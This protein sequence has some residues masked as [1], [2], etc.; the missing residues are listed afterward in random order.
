MNFRMKRATKY[1]LPVMMALILLPIGS[2]LAANAPY[3]TRTLYVGGGVSKTKDTY[4]PVMT[5]EKFGEKDLKT[6]G[7]IA[8]SPDGYLYIADTGNGR[9][10]K[11]TMDGTLVAEIGK[12]QLKFPKGVFVSYDN[13][14]YVADSRG[15]AVFLFDATG[16][17]IRQ[18]TKPD[19]VLYGRDVDFTP[20]KVVADRAGNVYVI[21]EGNSGGVIQLSREGDFFGYVGA[22]KT[23]LSLDEIIRRLLFTSEQQAQLK[24]NVPVSPIN[25]AIDSRGLIYTVTQG[26]ADDALKKFNMAGVNMFKR[27]SV[28]ALVADVCLSAIGNIYT[29]SSDGYI[30]E[31][32][33]DGEFLYLF[34]G[35]D[36]GYN[37][38]G[39]FIAAAGIAVDDA[40]TLYVLDSE[41]KSATVFKPT[42]YASTVH[43]ALE[44][45]QKGQYIESQTPWESALSQDAM[46]SLAYRGIGEAY[47]KQ[48]QYEKAMYAFREGYAYTGYSE[49]FWET[50]NAWLMQNL[51]YVFL[52]LTGLYIA[53]K[54]IGITNRRYGWLAPAGR[55]VHRLSDVPILKKVAYMTQVPRN[56]A[57]AFYGIRHENKVSVASSTIVY[58]LFF[59]AYLMGKYWTAF[60]FKTVPDGFFEIGQDFLTVFGV[61]ALSIITCNLICSIQDGEARLKDV[62]CS[63]A[64]C[65]MPYIFIKPLLTLVS[66]GLTNNEAFIMQIGD[67]FIAASIAVLILVMVK[68]IQ[69]YTFKKTLWC[70]LLTFFTM[71]LIFVT[72]VIAMILVNQVVDFVSSVFREVYFRAG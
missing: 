72:G 4:L 14:V 54:V 37:R 47:Y 39:L 57:D 33:T 38:N 13:Q 6:P 55:A 44:L 66:H 51:A 58:L 65:L 15:K 63:L 17:L 7:D 28:D 68:E 35:R 71:A 19:A 8:I 36:D 25:L 53:A 40:G 11:V 32:T 23:P 49:S 10:L 26:G 61:I 60:L 45:Y 31:Y 62:Y 70:L 9:V 2:A 29:V 64:Y 22:N 20:S 30:A 43:T 56:P 50:R 1:L 18:Y 41:R 42:E 27:T 5:F 67:F 59:L 52:W 3:D 46:F 12:G 69:A 34:G 24:L 48:G 21:S 16:N